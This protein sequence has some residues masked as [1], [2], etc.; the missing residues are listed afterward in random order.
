MVVSVL[1]W[2]GWAIAMAVT[3]DKPGPYAT[4]SSITDF[5]DRYRNRGMTAPIDAEVLARAGV[6][7]SLIPRTLQTLYVLELIGEDGKPTETL[8]ALRRSPEP[9]FKQQM[10]A[11][12]ND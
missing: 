12:I 5:I 11:W 9:E 2:N 4:T 8:E 10:V 3:K 1:H 6:S 7:D